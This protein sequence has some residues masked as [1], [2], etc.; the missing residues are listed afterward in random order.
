MKRTRIRQFTGLFFIGEIS[1]SGAAVVAIIRLG[2]AK[3]RLLRRHRRI[4]RRTRIRRRWRI[5]IRASIRRALACKSTRYDEW[6]RYVQV[7]DLPFTHR[8]C[9]W[10]LCRYT[11]SYRHSA[12]NGT[13]ARVGRRLCFGSRSTHPC[14][15]RVRASSCRNTPMSMRNRNELSSIDLSRESDAIQ[16]YRTSCTCGGGSRGFGGVAL[17]KG[18]LLGSSGNSVS[19]SSTRTSSPIAFSTTDK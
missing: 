18:F 13:I 5:E 15:A 6:K 9:S 8:K 7:R 19:I 10:W 17:V 2:L 12:R 14:L 4:R 11:S 3:Q 1:D 16:T